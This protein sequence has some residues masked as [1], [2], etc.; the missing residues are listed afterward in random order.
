MK[1]KGELTRYGFSRREFLSAMIAAGAVAI[2]PAEFLLAGTEKEWPQD[3]GHFPTLAVAESGGVWLASTARTTA[4][5]F[6]KVDLIENHQRKEICRLQP[7]GLTGIAPPAIAAWQNGCIVAFPVEQN[8]KWRI[9]CCF[10][11]SR[12]SQTPVCTYLP[13]EG[14]ANISPAIAVTNGPA[15]VPHGSGQAGTAVSSVSPAEM[16]IVTTRPLSPSMTERC[17]PRGIP[18]AR[19]ARISGVPGSRTGSGR[20]KNN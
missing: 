20:K 11:D 12:T 13:S 16:R 7:E 4:E 15:S 10:I 1:N 19:G 18:S 5:R 2:L 8:D 6:I 3:V 9:A 14:S 17:S